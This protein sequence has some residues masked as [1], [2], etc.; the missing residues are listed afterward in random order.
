VPELRQVEHLRG[1]SREDLLIPQITNPKYQ[2]PNKCQMP[3]TEIQ[4]GL[5]NLDLNFDIIC[6]LAFEI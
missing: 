4:N 5:K 1:K 2:I 6:D 3:I